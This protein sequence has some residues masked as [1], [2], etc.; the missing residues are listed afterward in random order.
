MIVIRRNIDTLIGLVVLLSAVT[1]CADPSTQGNDNVLIRVRDGVA[2][3]NDYYR[4]LQIAESAYSRSTLK[5]PLVSRQIRL[6]VLN[7]M[8]EEMVLTGFAKSRG[9]RL[10]DAEFQSAVTDVREDYPGGMF[11]Q[12]LLESAISYEAWT[13]RLK[14]RLLAEK[15]AEKLWGDQ[16]TITERDIAGYYERYDLKDRSHG[17]GP[18]YRLTTVKEF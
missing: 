8:I 14:V 6:N 7:Q 12:M 4:V 2:T 11:E 13:A 18:E 15:V 16:I 17:G 3:V 9:I 1:G 5:D 10:S